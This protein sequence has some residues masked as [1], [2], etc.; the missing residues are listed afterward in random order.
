MELG[1]HAH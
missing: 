1:M